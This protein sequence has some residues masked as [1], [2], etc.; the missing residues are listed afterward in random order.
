MRVFLY[1]VLGIY[2]AFLAFEDIMKKTIPVSFLWLGILFIPAGLL[3]E[4]GESFSFTDNTFSGLFIFEI[5][6]RMPWKR[7]NQ[8][9]KLV[10]LRLV[11]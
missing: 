5:N 2:M 7:S 8:D 1:I 6:R 9:L 11:V 10:F 4:G 3:T